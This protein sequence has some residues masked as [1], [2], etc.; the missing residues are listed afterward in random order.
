L[1]IRNNDGEKATPQTRRSKD[2]RLA[3]I[4]GEIDA[5]GAL[6]RDCSDEI[7]DVGVQIKGVGAQIKETLNKIENDTL[8]A[9]KMELQTIVLKSFMDKEKALMDEKKALMDEKK[10]LM[11]KEKALMGEKKALMDKEKAL[12]YTKTRDLK[13]EDQSLRADFRWN[14]KSVTLDPLT[15]NWSTA[16]V[17]QVVSTPSSHSGLTA[18]SHQKLYLRKPCLD[19]F[20]F[21]QRTDENIKQVTGCPGVGKSVEI[22]SY[23]MWQAHAHNKRVLYVHCDESEGYSVIFKHNPF[24]PKAKVC[25]KSFSSE[26]NPASLWEMIN[27]ILKADGV[28]IIVLD[29]ALL[30][31]IK[32]ALK[33]MKKHPNV[34]LITC[35][36]FQTP[37]KMS[38]EATLKLPPRAKFTM[39][40]WTEEEYEGAFKAGA[41]QLPPNSTSLSERFYYAGGSIRLFLMPPEATIFFLR[42]RITQVTDMGKLLGEGG[43]GEASDAAVNSIMAIYGQK[44]TIL[45]EFV[46]KLLSGRVSINFIGRARQQWPSNRAWQ[47]WVTELE[48]VHMAQTL[49]AVHFRNDQQ[50][51]SSVEIWKPRTLGIARFEDS[52]DTTLSSQTAGWLQPVKWTQ[53]GYDLLFRVSEHMGRAVQVTIASKRTI[54]PS[55]LIPIVKAMDIHVLEIVYVCGRDNFRTFKVAVDAEGSK[56]LEDALKSVYNSKMARKGHDKANEFPEAKLSFKTLCYQLDD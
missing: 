20:Q 29:G 21:L 49:P 45:S 31:L 39:D 23:A 28:D 3:K 19:L 11:D 35:T 54:D 14:A 42:E 12:R 8:P 30:W 7:K 22:F 1:N 5:M 47:G 4:E 15:F 33:V 9:E 13:D 16:I 38:Q 37:G 56:L 34:I 32:E 10:A 18:D 50:N 52:N 43:V 36:S 55:F 48:V 53:K 51:A 41:I 6:I 27:K 17:G 26:A 24:S 44:S 25:K 46:S 2:D 40:S